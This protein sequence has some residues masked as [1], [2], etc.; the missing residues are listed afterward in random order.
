MM[1]TTLLLKEI[2]NLKEI[3]DVSLTEDS[4][5]VTFQDIKE[6][7]IIQFLMDGVKECRDKLQTSTHPQELM[8][9]LNVYKELLKLYEV[10]T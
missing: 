6:Q 3:V 4:E 5:I 9:R 7:A 2:K 1:N 8:I 10:K